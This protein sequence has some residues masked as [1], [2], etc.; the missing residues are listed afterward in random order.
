[1][2]DKLELIYEFSHNILLPVKIPNVP[3]DVL[4]EPEETLREFE[5]HFYN[6][7]PQNLSIF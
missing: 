3:L 2:P 1:M 4:R 7:A 6:V 5:R